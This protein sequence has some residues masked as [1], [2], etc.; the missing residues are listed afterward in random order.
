M[1]TPDDSIQRPG[2]SPRPDVHG[3]GPGQ[4]RRFGRRLRA[5]DPSTGAAALLRRRSIRWSSSTWRPSSDFATTLFSA[6]LID[7][8]IVK[9][10]PVLFGSGI[11]LFERSIDRT[12][13]DLTDSTIYSTGHVLLHYAMKR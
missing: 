5:A 13:L 4:P 1:F 10:N 8:L 12:S 9:L 7:E 11:P 2:C 3:S 6:G